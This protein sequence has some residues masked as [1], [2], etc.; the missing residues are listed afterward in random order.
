MPTKLSLFSVLVE[1]LDRCAPILPARIMTA[2]AEAMPVRVVSVKLVG[3][4]VVQDAAASVA[5]I[6]AVEDEEISAS[7]EY[8]RARLARAEELS[9]E[10]WALLKELVSKAPP[11][12]T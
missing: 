11:E 3:V 2:V 9:D 10:R 12:Q 4:A 5:A 7:L 8:L 6:A 1:S